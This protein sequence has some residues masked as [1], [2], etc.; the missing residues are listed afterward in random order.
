[1]RLVLSVGKPRKQSGNKGGW[2]TPLI[3]KPT[4]KQTTSRGTMTG[5]P[6]KSIRIRGELNRQKSKVDVTEEKKAYYLILRNI[7]PLHLFPFY[8]L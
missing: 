8:H 4:N 1:M 5:T 2:R 7:D 3:N 6:R